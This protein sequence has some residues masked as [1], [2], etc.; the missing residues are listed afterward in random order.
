MLE[1]EIILLL[2]KISLQLEQ[3]LKS[4]DE[5]TD[6]ILALKKDIGIFQDDTLKELEQ[7][8]LASVGLNIH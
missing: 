1:R 3:V 4:Q 2:K 6:E 5:M 7:K 8:I